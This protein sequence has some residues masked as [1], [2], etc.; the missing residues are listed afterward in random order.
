MAPKSS[1]KMVIRYRRK[2]VE[3]SVQVSVGSSSSNNKRATLRNKYIQ[4]EEE[5]EEAS[6][7]IQELAMV[8]FQ[9][10]DHK[11]EKRRK[12]RG[13]GSGEGYQRYVYRVLKQ[14][15]PDMEISSRCMTVLNNL[16]NDMFERLANEASRLKE[17]TGRKTL[18]S[19]DIQGAVKLIFQGELGKHAI[20]EGIKAVNN[21][22]TAHHA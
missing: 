16:L 11:E 15:H 9:N 4:T 19:S 12:K 18:L 8:P 2:V 6:D 13:S 14:V 21:Y 3:S 7:V 5:E 22:T 17:Y 20:A 1:E 10:G